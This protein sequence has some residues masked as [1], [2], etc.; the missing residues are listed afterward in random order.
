MKTIIAL[1]SVAAIAIAA[2]VYGVG[3][4]NTEHRLHNR[5]T[6]QEG[7]MKIAFNQAFTI[8]KQQ[9]G[10]TEEY[11]EAFKSIFTGVADARYSGEKGQA[12]MKLIHESNPSFDVSLFKTLMRSIEAQWT[13]FNREQTIALSIQQEHNN[14]LDNAPSSFIVGGRPRL[15]VQLVT[16]TATENAFTTG[17]NDDLDLFRR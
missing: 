3:V 12:L 1:L 9:A 5:F 2:L 6:A 17:K 4:S 14:L 13:N 11:K 16:S 15:A 10:V 7:Q 8:L